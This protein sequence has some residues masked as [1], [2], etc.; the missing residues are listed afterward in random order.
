MSLMIVPTEIG[1]PIN[2][3]ILAVSEDK[4]Q[5]FQRNPFGEI[6]RVS[7]VDLAVVLERI[8]A[9]VKGGTI[10]RV[11]QTLMATNLA[12]GALV[13]WQVPV[14]KLDAAFDYMFQKDP[15]SGHVVIRSTDAAT[16]GSNYRLWTTLKVPQGF[17]MV[18]HAEFLLR[19]TGGGA[20][21]IDAG[22][23]VVRAGRWAHAAARD[24][25]RQQG[26]RGGGG[27]G[28]ERGETERA[29]VARVDGVEAGVR[30]GGDQWRIYGRRARTRRAWGWR[31]FS[32]WRR[33]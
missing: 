27:D 15:F 13:A 29:G 12:P 33:N 18:K 16:P 1:D 32:R 30:T 7:G 14:E 25:D 4:L 28:R 8:V 23:A 26:G 11:R 3:R 10:R 19:Q 5:G 9:M 2:A 22:E 21:S 31:S 17:S 6:A 24:G 20:F